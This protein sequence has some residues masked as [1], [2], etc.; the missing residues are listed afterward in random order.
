MTEQPAEKG[1]PPGP[2]TYNNQELIPL[3]DNGL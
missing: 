3:H 1:S 2:V